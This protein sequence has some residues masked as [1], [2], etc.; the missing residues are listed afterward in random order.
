MVL[1]KSKVIFKA[2]S[3]TMVINAII[4]LSAY[5]NES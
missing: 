2:Y 5:F 1:T 3:K 4:T